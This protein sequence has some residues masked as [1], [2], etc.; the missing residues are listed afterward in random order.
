[1]EPVDLYFAR[2]GVCR[3][4]EL[5]DEEDTKDKTRNRSMDEHMLL[6]GEPDDEET[7]DSIPRDRVYV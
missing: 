3:F 6:Y 7:T 1:M 4:E 2:Q 5:I